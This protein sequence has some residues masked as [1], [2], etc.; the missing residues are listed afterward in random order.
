MRALLAYLLREKKV[1]V[2]LIFFAVSMAFGQLKRPSEPPQASSASSEAVSP[3]GIGEIKEESAL[4]ESSRLA[5]TRRIEKVS[6]DL[7]RRFQSDPGMKLWAVLAGF[8]VILAGIWD[9]VILCAWRSFVQFLRVRPQEAPPWG[10]GTAFKLLVYLIFLEWTLAW[11]GIWLRESQPFGIFFPEVSWVTLATVL[12]SV[13]LAAL[14]IRIARSVSPHPMRDLG[15][16][17]ESFGKQVASGLM[18]YAALI[19]VFLLA[20][21]AVSAVLSRMGYEPPVQMPLQM[22]YEEKHPMMN[23]LLFFFIAAA[24][25]VFEEVL[26]RAFCY[27]ALRHRFGAA[28]GITASAVLFAVLHAHGAAFVPILVLGAGLTLLYE[29][30]GSVIPGCVLHAA[31]NTVM[32]SVALA[33]KSPAAS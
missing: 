12:R 9:I 2:I 30:S 17:R 15:M 3:R 21:T 32:L 20:V 31:H 25:P 24:G 8:L 6:E 11:A 28:R 16:I 10:V 23:A 27:R 13:V 5:T 4:S 14:M 18:A 22:I 26:F 7:V 29:A 1:A 19:P 33:L